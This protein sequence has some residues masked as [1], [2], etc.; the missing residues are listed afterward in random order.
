MVDKK[1]C[2]GNACGVLREESPV[3]HSRGHYVIKGFIKGLEKKNAPGSWHFQWGKQQIT[4]VH[5]STERTIMK[6][7]K[8]EFKSENEIDVVLAYLE[9]NGI[10]WLDGRH[11]W[12]KRND[13]EVGDWIQVM[14]NKI[15]WCVFG[16]F[17]YSRPTKTIDDFQ[18][19]TI[20]FTRVG[21]R[22][23][24]VHVKDGK[25]QET[26]IAKCHPED[27]FNFKTGCETA[28]DRLYENKIQKGDYVQ[29]RGDLTSE[30]V[31]E[32]ILFPFV[33]QEMKGNIYPVT[34]VYENG[35]VMINGYKVKSEAVHKVKLVKRKANEG[36]YVRPMW[37]I[38]PFKV[39]KIFA[40]SVNICNGKEMVT[41]QNGHYFVI[42][43]YVNYKKELHVFNCFGID[44]GKVGEP[45]GFDDAVGRKLHIGDE[46]NMYE[47]GDDR[48]IGVVTKGLSGITVLPYRRDVFLNGDHKL[49]LKKSHTELKNG[50]FIRGNH[51]AEV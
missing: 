36:E 27:E 46:V 45:A 2:A 11:A 5:Y 23:F 41:I 17:N 39:Q 30:E 7:F 38:G 14:D 4:H 1:G 37:G 3:S 33:Y 13:V 48:G 21:K 18:V 51:I 19:E 20:T 44:A 10:K 8:I 35:T 22:T 34:H 40:S 26:S 47:N 50:D 24:G 9:E 42:E 12:E 28:L 6:D 31:E 15:C 43:G 32:S 16:E 25:V 49:V 29:L